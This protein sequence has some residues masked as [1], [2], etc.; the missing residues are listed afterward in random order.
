MAF[1]AIVSYTKL[2]SISTEIKIQGLVEYLSLQAANILLDADSKNQWWLDAQDLYDFDNSTNAATGNRRAL[3]VLSDA[4]TSFAVSKPLAE[5]LQLSEAVGK[6]FT[7]GTVAETVTMSESFSKL[8]TY[9][10]TFT[11]TSTL[12]E[13]I[14]TIN[15]GKVQFF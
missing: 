8:L 3:F 6:G 15:V 11:E 4:I 1:K 5:T 10:R 12:S 14:Q 2:K 9:Q 13:S 7:M